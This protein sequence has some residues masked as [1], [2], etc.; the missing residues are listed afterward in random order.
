LRI[1]P[2]AENGL[3]DPSV[4][5]VFQLRAV[6]RRRIGGRIGTVSAVVLAELFATLDKLMGR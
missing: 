1:Q 3:S 5:L 2:T 6:D 4:A